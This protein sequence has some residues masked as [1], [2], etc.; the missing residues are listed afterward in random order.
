MSGSRTSAPGRRVRGRFVVDA[1]VFVAAVKPFSKGARR[2]RGSLA[3]LVR[4]INDDGLELF[5]NRRLIEEYTR[6]SEELGSE[7]SALILG[8]LAG[9]VSVVEIGEEALARCMPLLPE[10]ED[11]DA[12][13]AAT[14][15]QSR[16]VLIT[17]DRDFDRIKRARVIEVWSI[18]EATKRLS[19]RR[20]R[21]L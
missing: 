10:G 21:G 14:S 15:L 12:M 13:H 18:S 6:L 19:I 11:A 17:N 7:T 4:L 3:L 8:Q 5:R 1:N 20:G 9:K 2:D 16:A